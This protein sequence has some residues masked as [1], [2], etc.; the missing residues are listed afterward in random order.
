LRCGWIWNPERNSNR[1]SKRSP[2]KDRRLNGRFLS[3]VVINPGHAEL[4]GVKRDSIPLRCEQSGSPEKG[5]LNWF[6]NG[7]DRIE[8]RIR[9]SDGQ[10]TRRKV[11]FPREHCF[12][13]NHRCNIPLYT[14]DSSRMGE[15]QLPIGA[16]D[17]ILGYHPAARL[18]EGSQ[19]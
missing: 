11:F 13:F 8:Y 19:V 6:N 7:H 2:R 18:R 9:F 17:T 3:G 4:S 10:A 1:V 12:V 5:E 14:M 15:R 16:Q